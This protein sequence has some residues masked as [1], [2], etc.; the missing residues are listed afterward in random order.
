MVR[1]ARHFLTDPCDR[2]C[3]AHWR[4]VD[5]ETPASAVVQAEW[6]TQG[7]ERGRSE[8]ELELV[9]DGCEPKWPN[10]EREARSRFPVALGDQPSQRE[11][12]WTPGAL[13]CVWDFPTGMAAK[14]QLQG[15]GAFVRCL[16]LRIR[17]SSSVA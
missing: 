11:K 3:G 14:L 1:S 12:S 10:R 17:I 2:D 4:A 6:Q 7:P 16:H 8:T 5:P 13:R 15:P 9:D